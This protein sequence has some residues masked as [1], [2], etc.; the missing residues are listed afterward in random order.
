M[1]SPVKTLLVVGAG[2]GL[3]YSVVGDLGLIEQSL[4]DHEGA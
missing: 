3:G 1:A 4:H 2:A